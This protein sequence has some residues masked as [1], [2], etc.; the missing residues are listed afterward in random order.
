[1]AR[2]TKKKAKPSAKADQ[3]LAAVVVDAPRLIAPAEARSGV[4]QWLR[5]I[6]R[7]A[8]GKALK[9]LIEAKIGRASCRERV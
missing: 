4:G 5:E 1:M 3:T 8:P 9:R 7:D 2:T 6:G